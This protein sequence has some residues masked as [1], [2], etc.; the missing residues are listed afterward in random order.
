MKSKMG[1]KKKV[2]SMQNISDT[3]QIYWIKLI[4]MSFINE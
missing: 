3:A 1:G 2:F 4:L